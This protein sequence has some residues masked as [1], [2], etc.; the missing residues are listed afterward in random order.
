MSGIKIINRP[1]ETNK[2]NQVVS[3]GESQNFFIK[4][5]IISFKINFINLKV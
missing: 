1:L 4:C 5:R 2:L 3:V